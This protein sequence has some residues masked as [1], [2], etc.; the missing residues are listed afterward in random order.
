MIRLSGLTKRFGNFVAVENI[1]LSVAEGEIFAFLGSNGAGKTTTI[2]M[3]CGM[4]EPTAGKIE[5]GG[6]DLAEQPIQAKSLMG[7]MPDRPYLYSK[8]TAREY[9]LFISELYFVE[10]KEAK[11]RIADLLEEF[12]L[13][14]AQYDLIE[15]FS[16][17]M[18]Q[19][20]A[21][22]AAL[23]H[24]PKLL[25]VDEP[26]VGLDPR[27]AKALKDAFQRRASQ[28]LT[29]FMSTHS[30][31][32]AEEIASKLAIIN[33]GKIVAQGSLSELYSSSL[34]SSQ[35]LEKLFLEMTE[36]AIAVAD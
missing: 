6:Y 30:L 17:G 18:R 35:S 23:I 16:H 8:L 24:Q 5:I 13:T 11:V 25:I 15:T 2:R 14:H 29:I 26:M 12:S 32:M 28:G 3:M 1:N 21:M 4:I 27:G 22:C 19:R 7:V 36:E 20:L 33:R 9:L 31:S 10:Y 34:Q